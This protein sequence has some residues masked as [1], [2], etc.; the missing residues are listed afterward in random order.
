MELGFFLFLKLIY[1]SFCSL[2]FIFFLIR[3]VVSFSVGLSLVLLLSG[4]FFMGN[5]G[6]CIDSRDI[7]S[8]LLFGLS[9]SLICFLSVF[10][11]V[12]LW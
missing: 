5:V 6:F 9:F 2:C 7:G 11:F 8:L 3:F 1:V 10:S 12:G 4:F